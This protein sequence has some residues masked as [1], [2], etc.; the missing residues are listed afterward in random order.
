MPGTDTLR[1]LAELTDPVAVAL[2]E[3]MASADAE[4]T[5]RATTDRPPAF[6]LAHLCDIHGRLFGDVYEWAGQPRYVDIGK[7]G[8][9]GDPFLHH[10]WIQTYAAAVADQ[11]RAER[12]LADQRDPGVWADRAA[13]HWQAMLHA[14][15]FREGNGRATRIWLE[16]LAAEAGHTHDWSRSSAARNTLVAV[17]AAHGDL[18][19]MR[20]LLSQVAGGSLGVDRPTDA[21]DDLYKLQHAQAWGRV[22]LAFGAEEDRA[23]LAPQLIEL[24][25]RV[26]Q[27]G[28]YLDSRPERATTLEQPAEHPWRGL[29]ASI[30][31][32]LTEAENWPQF[33]AE[34]DSAAQSGV[35]VA[36]ELHRIAHDLRSD[37]PRRDPSARTGTGAPAP[38][39]AGRGVPTDPVV[40]SHPPRSQP[41]E[42]AAAAYSRQPPTASG[43]R[44]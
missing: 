5:L 9:T 33:A 1:T 25:T 13:R 35:D 43:P 19:P 11:I 23:R 24:S 40:A 2:F 34:M 10:P 4:G 42:R 17:A 15:P 22:G 36:G 14:H 28:A 31:P 18:E 32:G 8:Q 20:A 30:A 39:A 12:N 6:D 3:R 7:P 16:D 44:R 21:L 27:V 26:E 38:A 41:G 29:A 37:P